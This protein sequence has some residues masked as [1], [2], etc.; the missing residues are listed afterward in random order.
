MKLITET[1]Y[2]FSLT[3]GKDKSCI[4]Q[5]FFL[6]L[7]WRITTKESMAEKSLKEK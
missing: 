3:E 1:S 6:L 2:D 7:K 4:S 5:V